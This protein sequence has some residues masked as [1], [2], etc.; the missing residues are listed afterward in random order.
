M[1]ISPIP[2]WILHL[3]QVQ[4]QPMPIITTFHPESPSVQHQDELPSPIQTFP[5][6]NIDRLLKY[7]LTNG[8]CHIPVPIT[9]TLNV[10]ELFL[11]LEF[12]SCALY[13]GSVTCHSCYLPSY[14]TEK[15]SIA[16][17]D[18]YPRPIDDITCQTFATTR[19]KGQSIYPI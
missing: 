17:R 11:I 16:R 3:Q 5:H 6:R 18:S 10:S 14:E 1:C 15:G 2:F 12:Q 7:L 8:K 4:Y 9:T 13:I 19:P